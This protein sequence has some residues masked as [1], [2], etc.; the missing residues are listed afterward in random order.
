MCYYSNIKQEIKILAIPSIFLFQGTCYWCSK[1]MPPQ[2][3]RR[4][5]YFARE[6]PISA[7]VSLKK[8]V[9]PRPSNYVHRRL[10]TFSRDSHITTTMLFVQYSLNPFI[11]FFLYHPSFLPTPLFH[12]WTGCGH[13]LLSRHSIWRRSSVPA[14]DLS[15]FDGICDETYWGV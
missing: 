10:W 12:H 9:Y 2:T 13:R 7:L 8:T 15:Y 11:I 4:K 14:L 3:Q 6:T 1:H 5:V